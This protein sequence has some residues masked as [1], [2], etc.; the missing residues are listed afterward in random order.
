MNLTEFF[1]HV[2]QDKALKGVDVILGPS[3][4]QDCVVV[5]DL[6]TGCKTQLLAGTIDR[7]NW[8]TLREVVVGQRNPAPLYHVT[9]IVGYYSRVENW[10][11]SKLGELMDRR[12]GDY[13]LTPEQLTED[14]PQ[15]QKS[16]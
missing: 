3:P 11:K 16:A 6:A 5:Q 1:G 10:N 15:M 14:L 4:D 12:Q 9:R 2:E 13:R 7:H 8:E